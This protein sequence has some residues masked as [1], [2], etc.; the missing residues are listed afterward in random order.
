MVYLWKIPDD[1]PETLL[2][3]YDRERGPDRFALKRGKPLEEL[4]S[5]PP[6]FRFAAAVS[7]LRELD[8]LGN[9]ALVPL[10]SPA[11][12]EVL[13]QTCPN[14][15]QLIPAEIS[16]KDG[17]INDYSVVVMIHS[18]HGLDHEKSSY[19][20]VPG[21]KSIM[22]I[23]QAA[24]KDG[25]LGS[26]DAARDTEYLSNLLISDRLHDAMAGLKSLGLYAPTEMDWAT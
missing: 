8:D 11:V 7:T 18:V 6:R 21:T 24:Y 3:E 25:C 19:K 2:G 17:V 23:E 14:D 22:R 16:C 1:Y 26:H 15:V 12:A 9:N 5:K 10:V 13:R 20:C 4:P